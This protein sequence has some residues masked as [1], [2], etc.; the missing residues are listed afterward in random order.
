MQKRYVPITVITVALAAVALVGY[1]MPSAAQEMPTRILFD[2]NGG[3]VVFS[4]LAHNRDYGIECAKCHHESEVETK[5]PLAC[6]KCH[7]PAFDKAFV[8]EHQTAY[9]KEEQ[10]QKC[11][12]EGYEGKESTPCKECHDEKIEALVPTRMMAF[13]AQCIGCHKEMG[14]GP[15][16]DKDC[17][18]CH[19]R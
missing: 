2:N 11:H 5:D 4:H 7:V 18:L 13:H 12:H 19:L 15:Q 10:C 16:T 9:A 14:S 6:G 8:K 1:F 3:K 17:K